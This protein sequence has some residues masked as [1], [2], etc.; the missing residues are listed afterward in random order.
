VKSETIL[1]LEDA[2]F[3]LLAATILAGVPT[4]MMLLGFLR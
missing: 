2:A 1:H 3:G 4:T